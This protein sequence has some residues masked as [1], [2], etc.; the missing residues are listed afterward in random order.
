MDGGY[1]R[2]QTMAYWGMPKKYYSY[3]LEGFHFIVLDGNDQTDPPQEGY[4]HFI[5]DAQK[6][7]LKDDLS[8]NE[9][10]VVIFSHQSL[11]DVWS[12]ENGDE[13]MALLEDHNR[14]SDKGRVIAC[15]NGHSHFDGA[16]QINGIWYIEINSMSYQWL[17]D[18]YRHIRYG[19]EIDSLYPWIKY[20]APYK[21]PLFAEITIASNGKIR[22]RGTTSEY[23]GPSPWD[24]GFP[25]AHKSMMVPYISDRVLRF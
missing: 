5:G 9:L 19:P 12:V 3:E 25:D 21:D 18:A 16:Q 13:I 4:A 8:G 2:E 14:L 15:L 24:L 17:G 20:T 22:I 11:H 7:W 6:S 1:T 23:V 10:P